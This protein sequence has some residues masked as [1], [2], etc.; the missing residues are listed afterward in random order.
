MYMPDKSVFKVLQLT[1]HSQFHS[2]WRD[3]AEAQRDTSA[4]DDQGLDS[5]GEGPEGPE[6]PEEPENP[7]N[8]ESGKSWGP[9]TSWTNSYGYRPLRPFVSHRRRGE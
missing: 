3:V 6:G 4:P 2:R 1:W 5:G 9:A 8:P 7:E